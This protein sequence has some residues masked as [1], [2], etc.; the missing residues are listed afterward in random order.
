MLSLAGFHGQ[1]EGT[2]ASTS[3]EL[4]MRFKLVLPHE[5][6]AV[7]FRTLLFHTVH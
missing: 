6:C 2:R 3:I 1:Q 5:L 4:I 7:I